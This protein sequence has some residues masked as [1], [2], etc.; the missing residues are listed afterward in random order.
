[1]VTTSTQSATTYLQIV[2]TLFSFVFSLSASSPNTKN[3]STYPKLSQISLKSPKV[4]A[5][6]LQ[7]ALYRLATPHNASNRLSSPFIQLKLIQI[8]SK[9]LLLTSNRQNFISELRQM[10]SIFL[11]GHTF[12]SIHP[13]MPS[14]RLR[15]LLFVSSHSLSPPNATK[16]LQSSQIVPKSSQ[17]DANRRRMSSIHQN[18]AFHSN[19]D[20]IECLT[21]PSHVPKSTPI[22]AKW[23]PITTNVPS[24]YLLRYHR[25]SYPPHI[26]SQLL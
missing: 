11:L 12:N 17:I 20:I 21:L 22:I 8:A 4:V 14:N 23:S 24:T 18:I 6:L 5:N 9:L 3:V 2:S 10:L 16:C 15:L 13:N 26:Y 1:M 19:C 7:V 25:V